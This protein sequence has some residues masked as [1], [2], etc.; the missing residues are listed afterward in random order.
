MKELNWLKLQTE[1]EKGKGLVAPEDAS[2]DENMEDQMD[3]IRLDLDINQSEN[4][5]LKKELEVIERQLKSHA[6]EVEPDEPREPH[7]RPEKKGGC[8]CILF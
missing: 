2:K 8:K 6:S 7:S 5:Q 3:E 4:D 1:E